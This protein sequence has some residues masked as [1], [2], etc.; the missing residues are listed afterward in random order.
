PGAALPRSSYEA[1]ISNSL[2]HH[3]HDP[4]ILWDSVRKFAA[5]GAPIYIMDL[6]RPD[7]DAEVE[8]LVETY[9]GKEPEVLKRDFHNSLKAAFT[10]P[11]I[12]D[13]LREAG[14]TQLR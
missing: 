3:L 14:L 13:Q 2:L 5:P 8:R 10:V 4:S 12:N 7:S 6:L 1:V 11:E 9:A